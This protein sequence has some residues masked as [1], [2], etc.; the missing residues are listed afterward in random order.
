MERLLFHR[1]FESED[2]AQLTIQSSEF[3]QL[4]Q[5]ILNE[6]RESV[7]ELNRLCCAC[8]ALSQQEWNKLEAASAFAVPEYTV[9]LRRV[10]QNLDLFEFRPDVHTPEEYGRHMIQQS[11]CFD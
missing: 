5:S 11:G 9:Q 3:S 8:S 6:G 4:L 7:F 10:T 2:F 1:G